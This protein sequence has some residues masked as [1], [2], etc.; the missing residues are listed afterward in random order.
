MPRAPNDRPS[1]RLDAILAT[2]K[3][4]GVRDF[5]AAELE[6]I[7]KGLKWRFAAERPREVPPARAKTPLGGPS[8]RAGITAPDPD[9]DGIGRGPPIDELALVAKG[10]EGPVPERGDA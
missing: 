9:L 5:E 6:G 4:H 2:L 7:G 10:L 1:R 8:P 3:K